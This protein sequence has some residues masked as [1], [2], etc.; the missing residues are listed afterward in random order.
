MT[1]WKDN[2]DGTRIFFTPREALD[3]ASFLDDEDSPKLTEDQCECLTD[4]MREL[5]KEE[6]RP[7]PDPSRDVGS[8]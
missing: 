2:P 6:G 8:A 5:R 7:T 3:A 4:E 1:T